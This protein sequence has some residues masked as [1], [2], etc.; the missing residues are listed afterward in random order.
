MSKLQRVKCILQTPSLLQPPKLRYEY[1]L[2]SVVHSFGS[3]L[4]AT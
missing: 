1:H 3:S 2:G 4:K